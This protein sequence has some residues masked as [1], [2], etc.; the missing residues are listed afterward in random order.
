MTPYIILDAAMFD[1][2]NV[3]QL[4]RGKATLKLDDEFCKPIREFPSCRDRLEKSQA[5][6]LHK[7]AW[8]S[9]LEGLFLTSIE[10][11]YKNKYGCRGLPTRSRAL[12]GLKSFSLLNGPTKP[13]RTS[14]NI[15]TLRIGNTD[16]A[17]F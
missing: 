11:S 14:K 12:R 10:Y 9:V 7:V 3:E 16:I 6:K 15:G 4:S 5:Q 13:E 1:S 8:S 17:M 2:K